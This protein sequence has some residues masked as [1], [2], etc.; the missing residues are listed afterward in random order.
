MTPARAARG[1]QR[2]VAMRHRPRAVVPPVGAA[3]R[4]CRGQRDI[5]FG[6]RV[7]MEFDGRQVIGI[8]RVG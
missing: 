4:D 8:G 3:P 1:H 6:C 2:D 5:D 7:P